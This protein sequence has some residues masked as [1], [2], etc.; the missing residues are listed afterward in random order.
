MNLARGLRLFLAVALLAAWQSALVHPLE[1]ADDAGHLIHV[2]GGDGEHADPL[3]DAL[4]AVGSVVGDGPRPFAVPDQ[5]EPS[6][7]SRIE[8]PRAA[9]PRYYRSQAPPQVS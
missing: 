4:G 7:G 3:C 2:P 9:A 1:H 8:A 6:I 5:V